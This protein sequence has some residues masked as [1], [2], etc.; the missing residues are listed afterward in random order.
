MKLDK[1][2]ILELESYSRLCEKR[3]AD[4]FR[5]MKLYSGDSDIRKKYQQIVAIDDMV[6]KEIDKRIFELEGTGKKKDEKNLEND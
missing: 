2:F 3:K 5:D 4:L 6:T 1:L